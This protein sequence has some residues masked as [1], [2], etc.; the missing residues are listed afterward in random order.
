ME[1]NYTCSIVLG[2]CEQCFAGDGQ[3]SS[4]LLAAIPRELQEEFY[5]LCL[6]FPTFIPSMPCLSHIHSI[7]NQPCFNLPAVL[8]TQMCQCSRLQWADHYYTVCRPL[9]ISQR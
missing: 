2:C 4:V 3:I 7:H 5:G 8:S 6:A 1:E 9:C